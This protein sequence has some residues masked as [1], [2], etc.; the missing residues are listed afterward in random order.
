MTRALSTNTMESTSL[1]PASAPA[2]KFLSRFLIITV[3]VCILI[4][5][6][7]IFFSERGG[8]GFIEGVTVKQLLHLIFPFFGLY[9]FTLVWGQ[10][11]IGTC[12]PLIKKIF[13]GIG[14]FHRLEGIFAFIFALIHPVLLIGSLGA[15]TYLKYEFVGPN[16][17]IFVLLGVTALLLLIVTV[18]TALLMR[19][20]WLQKRWKKLH[21]ANYAVFILVF[22]HS[23]NLGTD[24]QGSPLQYL[25]MFFAVSAGLG[26]LYRI[27]RAIVKRRTA[28]SAQSATASEPTNSLNPPNS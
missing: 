10:I 16:K 8:I 4:A 13:P 18:T 15:V 19:L 24:I 21:Y 5:P 27:W 6:G 25:W 1:Q 28:M 26:T 2:G 22:I 9:A 11:I 17:K 7:Y 14:R 3:V 20:P 23:W 12:K